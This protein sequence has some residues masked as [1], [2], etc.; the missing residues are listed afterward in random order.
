MADTTKIYENIFIK[1]NAAG[2]REYI[3]VPYAILADPPTI[4]DVSGKANVSGQA[5]TGG[6]SAPTISTGADA[7]NYFQTQRF[8]GEGN[9]DTYYHAVDFGF[10]GHNQVD[11]HEYGGLYNFYQNTT[12]APDSG[13]LVG[14]FTPDGIKEGETLLKD[15]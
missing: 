7:A 6:I 5:F 4:P 14:A 11:F 13:S 8:R 1:K 9:A 10:A 12:G 2:D 3:K 15:K